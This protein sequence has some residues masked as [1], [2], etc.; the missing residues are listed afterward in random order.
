MLHGT[1]YYISGVDE[2]RA[3]ILVVARTGTDP[4]T[5]QGLLSLFLVPPDSP[6]LT[7]N[8]LPVSASLPEQQ[9]T[10]FFDDVRLRPRPAGRRPGRGLHARCSTA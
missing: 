7:A 9:F 4:E 2:R 8:A 1:K 10:L 5:G 6:G 3:L